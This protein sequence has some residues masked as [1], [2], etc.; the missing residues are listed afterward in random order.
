MAVNPNIALSFQAPKIESPIN[1]MT[2]V[3]QLQGAQQ[4]NQMRAMQ[5][6][7]LQADRAQQNALAQFMQGYQPGVTDSRAAL[8]FGRPGAAVFQQLTAAEK[9]R[10]EAAAKVEE[11]RRK[12]QERV[13]GALGR[14]LLIARADPS[15]AGLDTSFG[16]L[17]AEGIDTAPFRQQFAQMNPE[18]RRAAIEQYI[19]TNPEGRAALARV[20]PNFVERSTGATKFYEDT[21]PDSPTFG[22][23]RSEAQMRATPD[24]VLADARI[25]SEG[26]ANRGVQIRGQNLVDAR[27][28]ENAPTESLRAQAMALAN[29]PEHQRMLAEA[30]AAGTA[31]GKDTVAARTTLPPAIAQ[32]RRMLDHIDAMGGTDPERAK[33]LPK[34]QVR[35]RH[36]GLGNA[37][38][39]RIPGA[40]LV[41][42]TEAANFVARLGEIQG[43]AF[44]QAFETLKGGGAIT[45][46]EGEKA[47]QAITR[48]ST[49]QSEAEFIVAAREFQQVVRDGVRN[50]ERRL[51][52]AGG[53]TTALPPGREAAGVVNRPGAPAAPAAANDP[54]G[55]RR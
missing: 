4:Q 11:Q 1:M 49:A 23:R 51:Q 18:Q 27:A 39:L 45:E 14:A 33:T 26:A 25:R 43:G 50:A 9:A 13:P 2:Q 42:G 34:D 29:D 30:R 15:D 36:P 35:A 19:T 21:N 54:L 48:M 53:S 24:A 12:Q 37:V 44:L 10:A 7:E 22:Q 55:I 8:Q 6:E 41:P 28:R 17:D 47:T 52:Q 32:G 16:L 40:A 20:K 46:K 31:A 5:M 38:G 3:Q